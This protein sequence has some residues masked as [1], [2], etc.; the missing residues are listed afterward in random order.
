MINLRASINSKDTCDMPK[1]IN[2]IILKN[3]QKKDILI[4][5]S[6]KTFIYLIKRTNYILL[7]QAYI[8]QKLYSSFPNP[9]VGS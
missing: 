8:Q 4:N 5:G 1:E 2:T 6:N 9:F 3:K 7:I